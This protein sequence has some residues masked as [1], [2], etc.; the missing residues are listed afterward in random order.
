MKDY[1]DVSYNIFANF[2]YPPVAKLA[3]L[4]IRQYEFIKASIFI[5]LVS[6]SLVKRRQ[7]GN[8][9]HFVDWHN[10]FTM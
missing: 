7:G 3:I 5:H 10:L 9:S 8:V 2:E 1:F 6:N 4:A